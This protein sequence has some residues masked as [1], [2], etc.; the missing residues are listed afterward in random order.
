MPTYKW[1][2]RNS[3]VEIE[4]ANGTEE[5]G[6]K[7]ARGGVINISSSF[8]KT[9]VQLVMTAILSRI[10]SVD[11]YGVMAMSSSVIA[12]FGMFT[13]L[14][15]G[16]STVRERV[17]EH[18]QV[19]TLFWIGLGVGCTTFLVSCLL[20][21]FVAAF[22][23][24]YRLIGMLAFASLAMPMSALG[25]Q[26]QA[27]LARQARWI[28]IS[29]SSIGA[30]CIGGMI[31]IFFAWFFHI[32]YWALALQSV[33]AA[34]FN[35]IFL[36]TLC[37]WRPGRPSNVRQAKKAISFGS[38]L[39]L[40]NI[41]NYVHR[42]TDNLIVGRE[43][44]AVE[45]GFYSRGYNLFMMPLTMI[46]WPMAGVVMPLMARQQD[47]PPR[48]A[49]TYTSALASVYLITAP[50][51]GFLF[52][53][54]DDCVNIL[55][56]AKW[57]ESADVLRILAIGILWQPAY[58]S[59]GWIDMSLGR[60]KRHFQASLFTLCVYLPAY[61]IGV[62]GGVVGM[63]KA[64]VIANAI[65]IIPW[66]WWTTR[67]TMIGF[68]NIWRAVRSPACALAPAL[69]AILF[70][71]PHMPLSGMASFVLR[72]ALYGAI[73][74]LAVLICW[75]TDRTW[76]NLIAMTVNKLRPGTFRSTT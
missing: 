35:A 12:F 54:A 11:D 29:A 28:E 56:G 2:Q 3:I 44:G 16:G 14:G 48:F 66:L 74:L 26:H 24:D 40:F 38:F 53:F 55:Y 18:R 59:G 52:L 73:F 9:F 75:K 60:S 33:S 1:S 25:A 47:D 50:L 63:A 41:V 71:T 68:G 8:T 57:T 15:M 17:I 4:E 46:V 45:L 64:Y 62:R 37:R 13:D 39:L 30:Q 32:G 51:A 7:T 20:S 36:W 65:T 58:T 22:Y 72:A 76:A 31:A 21:P 6:R 43:L 70:I 5:M 10:L 27:I 23:R 67:G 49:Q 69:A 34:A 19:S 42:Q 61:L